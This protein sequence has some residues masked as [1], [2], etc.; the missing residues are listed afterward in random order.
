MPATATASS[1][2]VSSLRPMNWWQR[3]WPALAPATASL[4]FAVVIVVQQNEIATLKETVRN[5]NATLSTA[6]NSAP[7]EIQSL[8]A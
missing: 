1:H 2:G 5:L 3:W 8:Q 7:A 6:T 4:A